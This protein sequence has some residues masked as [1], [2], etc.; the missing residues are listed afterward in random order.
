MLGRVNS[1]T[2]YWCYSWG[3]NEQQK[4]KKK[5]RRYLQ[6]MHDGKVWMSSGEGGG[7]EGGG[8]EGRVK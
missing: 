6:G 1:P 5:K 3:G 8:G 2:E 7:G 4:I